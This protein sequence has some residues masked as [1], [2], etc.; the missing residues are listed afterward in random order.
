MCRRF[1]PYQVSA[2]KMGEY[3]MPL[4]TAEET[5]DDHPKCSKCSLTFF[6]AISI[7]VHRPCRERKI[8]EYKT[9]GL[10][11][12]RGNVVLLQSQLKKFERTQ[13]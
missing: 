9:S 6:N 8:D 5:R 13:R 10:F 12:V 4:L 2:S 1:E 7:Q 11:T 3:T